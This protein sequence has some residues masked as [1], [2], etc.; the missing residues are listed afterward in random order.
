[1]LLGL[2]LRGW[3]RYLVRGLKTL[4]GILLALV[5]VSVFVPW[6]I[7][8][9]VAQRDASGVPMAWVVQYGP[10]MLVMYCISNV[11][12]SS[13]ER[14]IYFSPAEIQFLIPGP[15]SRRKVL[16]YK[17]L[18]NILMI[19]PTMLIMAMV[20]RIENGWSPAV[21]VGLLLTGTFMQLFSVAL[22]LLA[23]A[24]GETV[25]RHGRKAAVVAFVVLAVIF[26]LQIRGTGEGIQWGQLREQLFQT[27]IWQ[28]VS[29]PLQSFFDVMKAQNVWPDL[30]PPLL[31]AMAV[32]A[33]I[34]VLIFTLDA[35]YEEAAAASSAR[36]YARIQRLRGRA[37]ESD[38]PAKST[39]WRWELPSFPFWG[40][41]G[42]IFWRQMTT[43]TRKL[44]RLLW[45]LVI[46]AL[47]L[48]GPIFAT[49]EEK[50]QD[51]IV[52]TL[53]SLG[54]WLA[55]FLTTLVPFDFRGDIDRIA[56]LKTLPIRPWKIALGQLLAPTLLLSVMEWLTLAVALVLSPE[57][58]LL[59]LA[60]AVYVPVF[61]FVIVG[62]ENLLFLLFPV[63]IMAA[64]P[65][66]FQAMG[67]NVLL[68]IGKMVGLII[69]GVAAAVVG[70]IYT[71]ATGQLW[72]GVLGAWPVVAVAGMI[73]VPLCGLA[74]T[75]FDVGRDT[76]A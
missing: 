26:Y 50:M 20:F 4:K 16:C 24:V 65:G 15:F 38:Q 68:A 3:F 32:L 40:G 64:T 44:G 36:I 33:A 18:L 35:R 62:L 70:V 30:L 73:L 12:F 28:F 10:A 11:L 58:A 19:V 5:G 39:K 25:Y 31:V 43:A 17:M 55:I 47:A 72:I 13:H 34:L 23:N 1:M 52:P 63:R 59:V 49:K 14:V 69:I 66:D 7:T 61:S 74:F 8:V 9:F 56:T 37:V 45:V 41:V 21:F 57:S 75:W 60:V 67:R 48:A 29:W 27:R 71:W 2:Q 46:L 76:P 51:V 54:A 6:L 22:G 53:L 42:P